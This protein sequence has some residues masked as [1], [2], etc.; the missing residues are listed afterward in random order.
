MQQMLAEVVIRYLLLDL[1]LSIGGNTAAPHVMTQNQLMP[2][3]FHPRHIHTRHFI[4]V[5]TL[6]GDTSE[7]KICLPPQ[8]IGL[9]AAPR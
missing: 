6:R 4:F 5:V 1:L 9:L 7:G 8:P 3:Q 2:R